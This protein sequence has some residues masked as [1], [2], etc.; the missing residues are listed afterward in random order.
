MKIKL[1]FLNILFS[2]LLIGNTIAQCSLYELPLNQKVNTAT[3]IFEGKVI[4]KTCFWNAQH[5]LIYTSNTIEVYKVFKGGI[6]TAQ[7][8]VIT[9]GGMIDD[10]MITVEPGL[11]LIVGDV[12]I[13][14]AG[15]SLVNDPLSATDKSVV[16]QCYGSLQGFFRYD[17]LE[18]SATVPFQKYN[19]ITNDLY[20]VIE[21]II[22]ATYKTITTFDVNRRESISK[23]GPSITSFTPTTISAGTN[24]I[25]TIDGGGFGATRGSS[26]VRFKN[27]DDGGASYIPIPSTS[28]YVS[29]SDTQIKVKVPTDAGTGTI[30]VVVNSATA[31]STSTLTVSYAESNA[32]NS[33]TLVPYQTDHVNRNTA[34]GLTWQMYTGFNSNTAAKESF[35]RAL[36]TWRCATHIN[37]VIGATTSTNIIDGDG[38]NVI[39]FDSGNELSAGVLGTCYTYWSGCSSGTVWYVAELDMA[40]DDGATWEYGPTNPTGSEYD[41]ESVMLHELGHGHQL[42]HVI[43]SSDVMNY[44]VSNATTRRT[45]NTNNR[46]AGDDIMSRSVVANSCGSGA[47]TALTGQCAI[48]GPVAAFSGTP[49]SGCAPLSVT[50]TDASTNTPTSWAWDMDNNGTTDYTIQNPTHVY[51]TAG[52]YSVKLKITNA[53]GVDSIIKTNY[54]TV[55]PIPV[56]G[57]TYT[58]NSATVDFTNSS[59]NATSYSWDFGDSNTSSLT[60]PSHTYSSAN[61]YT[62]ILT[63]SNSCGGNSVSQVI[64]IGVNGA[65]NKPV[66]EFSANTT[67]GCPP[68][69]VTFNDLSTENPTS[70]AWDVDNNGTIDYTMQNPTHVYN[71]SGNYSVK[72]IVTNGIGSDSIT[73]TNY[74]TVNPLPV[75]GFSNTV[76]SGTVSFTNTSSDA[77]S[78]SWDFGDSNISTATADSHTYSAIN[79]YTVTLIATNACGADTVSQTVIISSLAPPSPPV[80]DFSANSTSG[81]IPLSVNFTD[82]SSENPTSWEWDIDNDGT[83]DYTTQNPTHVYNAGGNYTVKLKASNGVGADSITKISYITVYPDPTVTVPADLT[84]CKGGMVMVDPFSSIPVGATYTWTNSNTAIGLAAS[85]NGNLSM[86]NGTNTSNTVISANITVT[87][88][89][90]GCTGTP[91]SFSITVIPGSTVS[92]PSDMTVCAGVSINASSFTST[93]AGASFNWSNSNTAIGLAANGNGDV[94]A[95]TSTNTSATII[96]GQVTVTPVLNGCSGTSSSYSITVDPMD[97]AGFSYSKTIICQSDNDQTPTINLTGGTFSSTAGLSINASTGVIGIATSTLGNYTITY[98]TNGICPNSSTVN[99]T[100]TNS[101]DASFSYNTPFCQNATPNPT[102]VFP[103]GA[104]AGTFSSTTG[105]NFINASTGEID[106]SATTPGDYTITNSIAASGGCPAAS[107]TNTVTVNPLP[108][109]GFTNTIVTNTVTFTNASIN[110][111]TYSWDFGDSN[112]ST[113]TDETHTYVTANTYSVTLTATNSCGSSNAAQNI[114]IIDNG[115]GVNESMNNY[116]FLIYPNP[117]TGMITIEFSDE[118]NVGSISIFNYLGEAVTFLS[119]FSGSKKWSFDLSDKENGVYH[120]VGVVNGRSISENIVLLK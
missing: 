62:V 26:E 76:N 115:V 84:I 50:F 59:S 7:V 47:M 100:I 5:T 110:A 79:T 6:T 111:D 73:K 45:L 83:V 37:W 35:I 42:G 31:T 53:N 69:S 118:V 78:Y 96:T 4:S 98:L 113:A 3:D 75:A 92:V 90:N 88:T 56:S 58:V 94:P 8:E 40:I 1:L 48:G 23:A 14:T 46:A 66:P 108:V 55:N 54:I 112:S 51:N 95:F 80:P 116:A 72:L 43:K 15:L 9:E 104:S 89:L 109:S 119:Q 11:N 10:R 28:Q 25:L 71:V 101:P 93:P 114:T 38:V 103:I 22:G 107:A 20:T 81:C 27:A 36:N 41:F 70:W 99:V 18:R 63:A 49:V 74:I 68:L 16:F 120:I 102:P 39:R 29:W 82:L 85:G 60:D 52:N 24:S 87:P 77:A 32:T 44:A 57:F 61:T 33:T 2:F 17:L 13:F 65:L 12:G 97:D 117:S 105:L 19:D 21:N 64:T 91:S 86:F 67:T 30:R 34:G 106:L